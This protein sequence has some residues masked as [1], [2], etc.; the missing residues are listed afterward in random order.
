MISTRMLRRSDERGATLLDTIVGTALMLVVF[1]GIASAFQLSLSVVT[2]NKA[3]AG[4]IALVNGRMEY[5]RSLSYTQ[6]GVMGGIPAGIV[7]QIETVS[8]NG[9][10]YMRRTSVLYTD[11]AQDG[12]GDADQNGIIADYKTIRVEVS[13]GS[14]QGERSVY[15]VG[16]VSPP[17]IES[18]VPGGTLTIYVVNAAAA[19]LFDAQVDIIN[20][21]TSPAINIRTFTNSAGVVSFIGAPAA[22]NYQIT[23]SRPGYSS[24]QTYPVTGQNPDPNPRHLTVANDQTTSATFE[25]DLVSTKTVETY[26]Q[27]VPMDWS[28]PLDALDFISATSNVDILGGAASLAGSAPYTSS[29]S[30]RSTSVAPALLAGW[31]SFSWTATEP[32]LTSIRY[33]VYDTSGVLI[34]ESA[35]SGNSLGFT[36][37]PVDLSGISPS[38]YSGLR[39]EAALSTADPDLSPALDSWT[40]SYDY[41]PVPLPSLPFSMRG[42]KTIGN[43]P[44]VYKYDQIHDSGA[45]ASLTLQNIEEDTYVLGIATSTG[46]KLAESCSP[47][48]EV[49]APGSTQTTRLYVLPYTANTL[50]VD[51]R[52]NAG[53]LLSEASVRL[54][55]TGYDETLSSASCGQTFFEDLVLGT[56]SIS[57]S[58]PGYQTYEN[59]NVNISSDI[60]QMSVVLSAL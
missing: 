5:L 55:K 36:V 52:S 24:A 20:T 28:D 4:A 27:I 25:I 13:W 60:S 32:P 58:R 6:I 42:S 43:N 56:Y 2:N 11:D 18:A 21:Q 8:W 14:R 29:G 54:Y 22:S 33:R 40:I 59:L 31:N 47:Q 30:V 23:V 53:V 3:R 38:T 15:L 48:P 12:T 37:S 57:V 10:S 16:R 51:V 44:T 50:L 1:V 39:L 9:I 41:G 45:S 34:P 19:A 49:L 17:G 7:P 46:H 26:A 35:L